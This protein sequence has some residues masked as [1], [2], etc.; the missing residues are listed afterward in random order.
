MNKPNVI[1]LTI[2]ALRADMLGCYGHIPSVTPNL[3]Q[4][5]AAGI[6]FQQAIT[7]GSWTQAAFPV[8]LTSTYAS[9][10]GGCLGPLS[11]ERPSPIAALAENGYTTGGF[12]TSPLLSRMYGYHRGFH[13]FVDL[14]PGESDPL[15]RRFKGGER[16]LRSPATHYLTGMLGVHMR[17]AR[18]YVSAE[19]LTDMLC[20][21]LENVEGPFFAWAHYMDVHWPYH[22]EERL[23]QPREIA[24]TWRDLTHLY[25]VNWKGASITSAQREHYIRLYEQAL[26]YT[27]DQIG[28][29]IKTLD[30]LGH[31]ANTIVIITSDHGEE[32][33]ERGRWGHLEIN[34]YD[35]ILKVPLII[36]LP[37]LLGS[38]VIQRQVRLLD[39]MPT[40]L[41]LCTC[42]PPEGLQGTSLVPLWTQDS[43]GNEAEIS[44]SE[45]LRNDS[46]IVAVRTEAFKYIW[47]SR[48]PHQA[49]LHDLQFDPG[50]RYNVSLRYPELSRKFQDCVATHISL[51]SQTSPKHQVLEPIM[52][53]EILRRLRDLGYVE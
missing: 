19:E 24:Q 20:A 16:L 25:R 12:S 35:E 52:E 27:D 28:R 23:I 10:H 47:D 53:D 3:D 30:K 37:D 18:V 1:L 26:Q 2:D 4:L 39:L 34:L 5:S 36:N 9:M 43:F 42:L 48:H 11:L 38:R 51:V 14:V 21:W 33:M 49:K 46:H 31:L 29:F 44:I 41:D 40:I 8:L 22:L 32:F 17:P 45:R 15:L 6:R 7:G 50:E 13:H